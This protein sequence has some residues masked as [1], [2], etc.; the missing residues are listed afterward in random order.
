MK[1]TI[2]LFLLSF[3]GYAQVQ[4][5]R[6]FQEGNTTQLILFEN[7]LPYKKY[8]LNTSDLLVKWNVLILDLI[9]QTNGY[10]PNVAAR[11]LAY[12]N[13]AA[14]ESILPAY[15]KSLSMSGQIQGYIRPPEF[16]QDSS[17]FIP[18]IA[19]NNAVFKMVDYMFQPAPYIWMEKVM[20]LRDS[21]NASLT[22]GVDHLTLMKSTNYGLSVADL[23]Y[24]YSMKDGGHQSYLRSYSLGYKL[25][26]CD[27]CFEINRVADLENTGPLHPDWGKTRAFHP[28]DTTDFGINPK[29]P[30]SKYKNSPFYKQALEV[31]DESKTVV[32]G[33]EKHTI[34]NFWDDAASF[35]STATGHSISILTQVLRNKSV[36]LDEGA[37]DYCQLGL[38]IHDAMIICWKSKY[39]HNLIRPV[40]Y[41]KKY[42]DSRWE[43]T[44]LTP[45]FPEFPSGH[46]VQSAAMATVLTSLMGDSVA[47]TDYSKYWVGE[48]RNFKNFWTAA[49][50]TSI[51]R[52]YG[53]IHFRDALVQGQEMGRMV[54]RNVLK[55][56]FFRE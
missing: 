27:A 5:Q 4:P 22:N 26:K 52:L 8:D 49:N 28:E 47:F 10:S 48:P 23:I 13:L 39:K 36:P 40:A 32:T 50:E 1:K 37:R 20:A 21:V 45:P 12:I 3:Y 16:E 53:G 31:Y 15:P 35:T 30:F 46:S 11:S 33:S 14:Y 41:I 18:Q 43:A 25:P 17:S 38:A 9:E 42:I 51:S 44:L 55:L 29:V 56:K 34:A 54:G 24:L 7:R 19:L 2:L 6:Q